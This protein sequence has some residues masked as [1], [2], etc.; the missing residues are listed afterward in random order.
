MGT[1]QNFHLME[2][3]DLLTCHTEKKDKNVERAYQSERRDCGTVK[4][5]AGKVMAEPRKQWK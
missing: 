1:R 2:A 3:G 4:E 5:V